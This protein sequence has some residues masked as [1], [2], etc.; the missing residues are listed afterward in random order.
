MWCGVHK[1][2]GDLMFLLILLHTKKY[3]SQN[4]SKND[5]HNDQLFISSY[6]T[7]TF[8]AFQYTHDN[9]Q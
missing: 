2:V 1:M 3:I 8:V 9:I 7:K 6:C 4:S 5:D